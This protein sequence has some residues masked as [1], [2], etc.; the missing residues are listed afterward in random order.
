MATSYSDGTF[1]TEK[2][3]RIFRRVY[4]AERFLRTQNAPNAAPFSLNNSALLTGLQRCNLA[5][6]LTGL[7]MEHAMKAI[8]AKAKETGVGVDKSFVDFGTFANVLTQLKNIGDN[9]EAMSLAPLSKFLHEKITEQS[10]DYFNRGKNMLKQRPI[11]E[12]TKY[13]MPYGIVS[14]NKESMNLPWTVFKRP[15]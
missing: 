15:S 9:Y 7:N 5:M 14:T 8:V 6:Q 3:N 1:L 12:M 11:R 4:I 13:V 2:P 10:N